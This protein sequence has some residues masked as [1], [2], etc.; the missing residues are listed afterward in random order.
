[1]KK[2]KMSEKGILTM[3]ENNTLAKLVLKS[4]SPK[5]YLKPSVTNW[6]IFGKDKQSYK[7]KYEAEREYN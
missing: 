6:I 2:L 1:M 7:F 3:R 4:K 5:H